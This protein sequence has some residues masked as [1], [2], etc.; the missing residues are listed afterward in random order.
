M[1]YLTQNRPGMGEYDKSGNWGWEFFPPPY[2]FLA[3]RPAAA[4]PAPILGMG[5]CGC[6]GRGGC[7]GGCA[8]H[9]HGMGLFESGL[10]WSQWSIPEWTL[11]AVGSYLVISFLG[12]LTRGVRTVK[13]VRS[14]RKFKKSRTAE[15]KREL[16]ELQAA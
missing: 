15:L 11:V 7:G 4:M 3:P 9:R 13:K 5:G 2:D 1:A 14:R 16:Q 6:G 12:D 8:S 10:D